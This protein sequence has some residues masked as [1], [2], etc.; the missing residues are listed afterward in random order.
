LFDIA[1]DTVRDL[2]GTASVIVEI[3]LANPLRNL[4]KNGAIILHDIRPLCLTGGTIALHM[5][6][7][8]YAVMM[9]EADDLVHVETFELSPEAKKRQFRS[10]AF[11]LLPSEFSKHQW[12]MPQTI[13]DHSSSV[14]NIPPV[15]R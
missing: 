2:E 9:T 3:Q 13:S 4:C 15:Y 1:V 7:Q 11:P 6:A 14:G 10:T 12:P 8:T 5:H